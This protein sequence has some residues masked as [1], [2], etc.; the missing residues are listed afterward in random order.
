VAWD[1][2]CEARRHLFLG[3][4]RRQNPFRRQLVGS[5]RWGVR[6]RSV[7]EAVAARDWSAAEG[8]PLR[9]RPMAAA[10]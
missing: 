6:G 7:R 1:I 10:A 9:A 4:L 5:T 8:V 2:D 3:A